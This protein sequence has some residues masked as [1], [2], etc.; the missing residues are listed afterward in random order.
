MAPSAAKGSHGI[1]VACM[2][3]HFPEQLEFL[4]THSPE[5]YKKFMEEEEEEDI[6][7]NPDEYPALERVRH[8][9]DVFKYLYKAMEPARNDRQLAKVITQA[10]TAMKSVDG[11]ISVGRTDPEKAEKLLHKAEGEIIKAIHIL[12]GA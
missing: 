10:R 9:A 8:A 4:R 3:K 2:K 11:A 6:A 12:H 7:K 5:T 1:C